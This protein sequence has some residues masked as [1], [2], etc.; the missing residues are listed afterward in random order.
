MATYMKNLATKPAQFIYSTAA[1]VSSFIGDGYPK[2][3]VV[4][5]LSHAPN[6]NLALSLTT[7]SERLHHSKLVV[8]SE[9]HGSADCE[10]SWNAAV[11]M[12]TGLT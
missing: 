3:K 1:F 5:I 9:L 11:S 2:A 6:A 12:C 7:A 8:L 10:M 4:S